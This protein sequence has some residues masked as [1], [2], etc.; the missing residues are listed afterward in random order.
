MILRFIAILVFYSFK[1]G[2]DLM[3]DNNLFL[4]V[5]QMAPWQHRFIK[6]Q[7]MEKQVIF[8]SI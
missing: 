1:L 4:T 7:K 3:L 6:I 5:A 2:A 8:S